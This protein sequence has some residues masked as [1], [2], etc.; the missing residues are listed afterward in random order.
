MNFSFPSSSHIFTAGLF[1]LIFSA[2]LEASSLN[3]EK[4][5]LASS[6]ARDNY[7]IE[8]I[9]AIFIDC[10]R[11]DYNYIR[12]EISFIDYV[13]DQ[14]QADIHLFITV[15]F[16]GDGGREYELTFIGRRSFTDM[17]YSFTQLIGRNMTQSEIRDIL[18]DAIRIGLAPFMMRTPISN[19]F[20]LNFHGTPDDYVPSNDTHDPWNN[21]V[22]QIYFGQV[23]LELESNK[24][25]LEGRWGFNANRVTSD[26]KLQF[27]PY[28]N[29]DYTEINQDD[30]TISSLRHR[31][32]IDSYAIKSLTDHWSAGFFTYYNTRID[33]N[34]KHRLWVSPGIE[35]SIFPYREATR[36]SIN[37]R[38]QIGYTH[39]NYYDMTIFE[40]EQEDLLSQRLEA[41]AS[42]QQ[43]WGSIYAGVIGSH[44]F[45]DFNLRRIDFYTRLSV[46]LTEGLELSLQNDFEII[47]DQLSLRAKDLNLEDILLAQQE[48]ATDFSFRAMIAISY[49]FGS[50][51]ANVV[52]TRF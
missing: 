46:R 37:F 29:Y 5:S 38:Y 20:T 32:G 24:R 15:Q 50:D 13:R 48:L 12:E 39:V 44:Y 4:N 25:E 23:Q 10:Q 36:R 30:E 22:F 17:N 35:Y 2:S 19:L 49:T 28:F 45:H 41:R 52:N 6:S 9:P 1:L 42:Y 14:Q 18:N 33:N 8:T 7:K 31:N 43:P 51:F 40:K 21:W 11:C 27:R 47:Q 34:L 16:T 3:H 26:W